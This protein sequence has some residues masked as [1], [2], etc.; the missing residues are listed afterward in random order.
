MNFS[1]QKKPKFSFGDL[2]AS[3][4]SQTIDRKGELSVPLNCEKCII[5]ETV[6]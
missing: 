5:A 2:N 6:V 3:C 1:E 4:S